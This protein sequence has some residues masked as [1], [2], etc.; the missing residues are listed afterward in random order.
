M[1]CTN[2][3]SIRK[4]LRHPRLEPVRDALQRV[5]GDVLIP[6]FSSICCTTSLHRHGR[7]QSR[8]GCGEMP[9]RSLDVIST[10]ALPCT[11]DSLESAQPPNSRTNARNQNVFTYL[12]AADSEVLRALCAAH[13]AF[14]AAAIF[15]RASSGMLRFFFTG[16]AV[17]AFDRV[18][19][20]LIFAHRA[21]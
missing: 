5:D 11:I 1:G 15:A 3:H 10:P 16:V 6:E 19:F 12:F 20:P 13:R 17:F 7:A 8:F 14:A 2:S 4:N 18:F 9:D 21:F